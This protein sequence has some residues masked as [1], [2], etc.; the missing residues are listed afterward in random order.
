VR[1]PEGAFRTELVV[2][3]VRTGAAA[4]ERPAT[5]SEVQPPPRPYIVGDDWLYAKIYAEPA[6]ADRILREVVGPFVGRQRA[7]GHAQAWH[8]IR[9][10]DPDWHLRVRIHGAG[11]VLVGRLVPAL[12]DALSPLIE[13]G[14]VRRLVLDTYEPETARYG[15]PVGMRLAERLFDIDSDAVLALLGALGPNAPCGPRWRV[16]LAGVD[17]LLR[18]LEVP[19]EMR[20]RSLVSFR[21]SLL[22]ELADHQTLR[23][24][25]GE[26]Y[27]TEHGWV[28]GVVL[29]GGVAFEPWGAAMEFRAESL[30][31]FAAAVRDAQDSGRLTRATVDLALSY[32][33]MFANRVL[34]SV[35]RPQELVV[36]DFLARAY[37]TA[38]ECGKAG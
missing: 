15:G 27:R 9:Y 20:I 35:A 14:A 11:P 29:G 26:R 4:A 16:V 3:F 1:G 22:E 28:E 18:V 24:T 19:V 31:P 30:R 2:P 25:L 6:T 10:A 34:P 8:F 33:H 38:I 37:R 21:D 13:R 36:Y 12:H 17:S 32:A 7:E 23:R 5:A